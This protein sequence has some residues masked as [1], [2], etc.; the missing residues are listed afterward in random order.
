MHFHKFPYF[1]NFDFRALKPG[2]PF[3]TRGGFR[4][5]ELETFGEEIYRLEVK[6]G[7][8]PKSIAT[9]L[10]FPPIDPKVKSGTRLTV[11]A[12][13]TLRLETATGSLLLD[14]PVGRLFGE[15]GTGSLFEFTRHRNDRFYGLG[16]KWTG[17]EHSHRITKFWNTDVWADFHAQSYVEG[18]PPADPVYLSIPYLILK[19][20]DTYLGLLIDNPE[21]TFISTGF[22]ASIFP[23]V[24]SNSREKE[25]AKTVE[26][27]EEEA[28]STFSQ[29]GLIHLG[30]ESGPAVLILIVGPSLAE[31]TRKFQRLVGTTP[32]PPAW[33]LGYHQCRWG[34]QSAA[35]L[36]R[37][38]RSFRQH[39]IPVD[40]LWLDIDYMR[41][42]RVFT[43]E[44]KHFEDPSKTVRELADNG[45]HVIPII[46]PGVKL[47]KGYD[48]YERGRKAR[49][50]C[51]NSQGLDFVGLVWPGET[52]FPDF[53]LA[54][55]RSWWAQET[56]R[57]A[58]TGISGAWLDMNDPA[59]GP[60]D[61]AEML[62][63][64]GSLSHAAY[65]NLYA[66]GMAEAT[67][68]GFLKANP[69]AR[70]FLLSRSGFTGSGR[71]CAIWTGDN[72]SNYHHLK[73]SIATTLNLSLSGIPFNAPDVGGFGG[74]ASPALISDWFK[75]AFLFPLMRNHSM[76][77][78][79][80]QEPWNFAKRISD[81]LRH[82][83]QLRYRLRP[84]LYQLFIANELN[85]EAILRPLLYDFEDSPK[86]PLTQVDD[87]FLVGP[88][89]LQAPFVVENKTKRSVVLP[90]G[91]RWF[92]VDQCRWIR[93]GRK[94]LVSA[95]PKGT[96]L[97][98]RDGA[99]LPLARISPEENVFEGSRIDFHFY[100]SSG[101][102]ETRYTFDDG[103]TFAYRDGAVSEVAVT[104]Q[105]RGRKLHITL[106]QVRS[107]AGQGDFTFTAPAEISSV[108]VNG[109]PATKTG[110][111]GVRLG[112]ELRQT[113]IVP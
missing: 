3:K 106:K 52:V 51:K 6:K 90:A 82:Y 62:F 57:F 7:N 54:R 2:K 21:A 39:G 34:Y 77:G 60:S 98:I 75:A 1:R 103:R 89:I 26:A 86:L 95:T 43:F 41:G 22:R 63:H 64:D 59:T 15:C 36:N 108:M 24:D 76:T 35:D 61:N 38:D 42:Y 65:H 79:R 14:S 49:A 27:K 48:I 70:P 107:G 16:E 37:L 20:G 67:R 46:D 69:N 8:K 92:D 81:V 40:G 5:L 93:G 68:E 78:T 73:T 96:P 109:K 94:L 4:T 55:A 58:S 18:K 11:S 72:Y 13:G 88:W 100:L 91:V 104:A 80:E 28:E 105:R 97:F 66:R 56:A 85:G 33:A 32:R 101:T 84:Y 102:A 83:I 30:S 9:S 50:F 31:L 113:W 29:D 112:N 44:K 19:R 45:R 71:Y 10:F 99:I 17:F 23:E 111:Q 47:E 87:Q 12:N 25:F 74:D 110:A 53:S